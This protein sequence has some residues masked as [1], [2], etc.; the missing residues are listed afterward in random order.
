VEFIAKNHIHIKC[1]IDGVK[2]NS[3]LTTSTYNSKMEHKGVTVDKLH[4]ENLM[5]PK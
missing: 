1:P 5:P 4:L 3:K 2:I